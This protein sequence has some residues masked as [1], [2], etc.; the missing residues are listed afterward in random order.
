[1][2]QLKLVLTGNGRTTP[3]LRAL[4]VYYPRFSYPRRYLPAVYQDDE[5]SAQFLERLL[6]NPEGFYTEIEGKMAAVSALFDARSAPAETLDWLAGWLGLVLDPLWARIQERR[7][8][9]GVATDRRRLF[10]RY[11]LPLYNQRGTPN[12]L[13]FAL[14][15]LLDPCLETTMQ[16]F[17]AV[18]VHAGPIPSVLQE[19]L[20]R[21]GLPSPTPTT[22]EEDLET[23]LHDYLL[24]PQR[25]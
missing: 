16:Q 2:L 23:L 25:P 4:R 17:K 20:A 19:E 24:T 14:H 1:Y 12:G 21:L 9:N 13:Q 3:H 6:A 22:S 18:A 11:A 15:L 5:G 10:I 8:A 7:Q